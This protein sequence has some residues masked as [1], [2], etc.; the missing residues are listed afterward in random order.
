MMDPT[1][2]KEALRAPEERH[3]VGILFGRA[4]LVTTTQDPARALETGSSASDGVSLG[5][6]CLGAYLCKGTTADKLP[7]MPL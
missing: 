2:L 5:H 7:W 3:L 4:S 1:R 6:C